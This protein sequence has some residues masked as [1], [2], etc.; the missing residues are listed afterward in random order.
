[1]GALAAGDVVLLCFPFSDLTGSKLRPA[2]LMADVGR[3]DWIA[4]LTISN[5][6]ADPRAITLPMDAFEVGGLRR[7]SYLRPGKI[8]T[9]EMILGDIP[10]LR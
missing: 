10:A 6:H 2:L 7:V 9:V 5:P 1:M 8:F 3:G 4:C